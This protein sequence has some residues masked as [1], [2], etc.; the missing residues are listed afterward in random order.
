[1]KRKTFPKSNHYQEAKS[2][3]KQNV[4]TALRFIIKE[5]RV[6]VGKAGEREKGEGREDEFD[7]Q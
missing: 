5:S 1:L 2:N 4:L 6:E 7:I 3:L